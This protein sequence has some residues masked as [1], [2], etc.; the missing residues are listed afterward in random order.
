MSYEFIDGASSISSYLIIGQKKE[1]HVKLAMRRLTNGSAAPMY[2]LHAYPNFESFS[3][4]VSTAPQ[5]NVADHGFREGGY[6]TLHMRGDDAVRAFLLPGLA[7]RGVRA[8]EFDEAVEQLKGH[9]PK[10]NGVDGLEANQ[11]YGEDDFDPSEPDTPPENNSVLAALEEKKPEHAGGEGS[12]ANGG[13]VSP[14]D[15]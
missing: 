11:G 13:K 1:D 4:D 9:S 14:Q 10:D 7:S 8:L 12:E 3:L 2:R 15:L 6:E 5:A